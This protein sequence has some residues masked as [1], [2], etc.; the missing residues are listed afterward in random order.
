MKLMLSLLR[1]GAIMYKISNRLTQGMHLIEWLVWWQGEMVENKG[2]LIT[3]LICGFH[4][5]GGEMSYSPMF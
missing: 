2:L 3:Q 5:L 1:H 4:C